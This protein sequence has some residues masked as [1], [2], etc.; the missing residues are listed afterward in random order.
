[1][2][3]NEDDS[4]EA[5]GAS[6]FSGRCAGREYHQTSEAELGAKLTDRGWRRGVLTDDGML[7]RLRTGEP[8]PSADKTAQGFAD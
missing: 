8:V 3:R 5:P 2:G 4:D 6:L 1:M 7:L